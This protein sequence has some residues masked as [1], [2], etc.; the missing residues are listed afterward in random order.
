MQERNASASSVAAS[1]TRRACSGMLET[2]FY[3]A[4]LKLTGRRCLVVGGG[5]IGLEKVEGLLACDGRVV[6]VAPD[7][8]P[9]LRGARRRGLDR[10]DPAR[11]RARRP[12]AHVHR[13]RRDRR[14]RH[15]HPRLRGRGAARDARQ[16]RRRPAAVQLHPAG[17]RPHRP[18][19]DRDLDRRRVARARQA[20]Q[21]PDRGRVRRGVRAARRDAQRRPRLG[22]GD[23]ARPT[24]TAR[25][26]SR[27]SSTASPTRSRCCAPGTRTP[28]AS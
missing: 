14:H 19:R 22:E 2:P 27:R 6:L 4:C 7:A 9:E 20:D 24:R 17:D 5:E 28:C 1:A 21:A 15:E 13:D 18:A 3:I 11:V 26:S 16:H 8:V 12:R 10:V 25:R 23:A